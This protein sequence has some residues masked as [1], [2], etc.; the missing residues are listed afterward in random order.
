MLAVEAADRLVLALAEEGPLPV[1]DAARRLL[2]IASAP[3]G[4]AVT[5]LDRLVAEDVRLV[6]GNGTVR[7]ASTPWGETPLGRAR[8]AV[9]DLE[10]TG[11]G[12]A[13]RIVEA[14]VVVVEGGSV[15]GELELCLGPRDA[16][17]AAVARVIGFGGDAVLCGHN[18]RF[19]LRFLDRELRV[20]GTRF[21]APVLD[22][23][24]LAR[25]LVRPRTDGLALAE[26]ADFLGLGHRPEHRALADARATADLLVHLLELAEEAGARTVGDVVALARP[27]AR[28]R[29]S[30]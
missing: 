3:P 7:L 1:E 28:R 25:R 8:F 21:A 11:L 5:L 29:R 22:T 14:A 9:V 30:S 27:T 24:A 15:R 4:L 13:D 17:T 16:G 10:T 19:D 2:A 26:L 20:E 18:L 12:A 23:L 6:R